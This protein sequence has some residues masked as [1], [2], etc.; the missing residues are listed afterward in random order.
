MISAATPTATGDCGRAAAEP[1]R[2][3]KGEKCPE[4]ARQVR[5]DRFR[6]SCHLAAGREKA[7]PRHD[8][9][10]HR[11]CSRAERDVGPPGDQDADA[12]AQREQEIHGTP[13]DFEWDNG[14][15]VSRIA[16]SGKEK[17]A[18]SRDESTALHPNLSRGE[19]GDGTG[20]EGRLAYSRGYEPSRIS[21]VKGLYPVLANRPIAISC[22]RRNGL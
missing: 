3:L 18:M 19:R 5:G 15:S 10:P 6:Q 17:P 4:H 22:R 11:K 14:L 7:P 9:G 12:D 13:P 2:G 20:S 16:R 21:P 8:S 1:S